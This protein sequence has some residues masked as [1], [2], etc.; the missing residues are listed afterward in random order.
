M[1]TTGDYVDGGFGREVEAPLLVEGAL[2]CCGF[3]LSTPN[4]LKLNPEY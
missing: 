1:S 4:E 3:C 2:A